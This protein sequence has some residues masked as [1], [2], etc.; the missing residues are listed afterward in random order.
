MT[1]LLGEV[2][3]RVERGRAGEQARLAREQEQRLL[4]AHAAA[5]GVDPA[6]VDP[7]ER[8]RPPDDLRH[9]R[10][11]VDLL[12]RAPRVAREPVRV[13]DRE[14]AARGQGAPDLRVAAAVEPAAV[15]RDDQRDPRVPLRAV[16]RGEH[17]VGGA[18][19]AVR[20]EVVDLPRADER[21]R[22]RRRRR[23]AAA[24]QQRRG[25]CG[26][27]QAPPDASP[28]H[29]RP[30]LRRTGGGHP[31][32]RDRG[33]R[34]GRA[35]CVAPPGSRSRSRTLPRPR[36]QVGRHVQRRGAGVDRERDR[37]EARRHA[38][39]RDP[40]P[41]A[42]PGARRRVGELEPVAAL[43]DER[44]PQRLQERRVRGAVRRQVHRPRALPVER[45]HGR[46]LAGDER[47]R[48]HRGAE[49]PVEAE[50]EL[51]GLVEVG[52]EARDVDPVDLVGAGG[53]RRRVP[54]VERVAAGADE[55]EQARAVQ[56]Q[57]AVGA[58]RL[59]AVRRRRARTRRRTARPG[60]SS[61]RRATRSRGGR[62]P[63]RRAAA[64][65]RR[66]SRRGARRSERRTAARRAGPSRAASF[67]ARAASAR[68][69]VC[70]HAV[71]DPAQALPHDRLRVQP[72]DLV[73]D[74]GRVALADEQAAGLLL[75]LAA[76]GRSRAAPASPAAAPTGRG[77]GGSRRPSRAA[78][79]PSSRPDTGSA[80]AAATSAGS[81]A[82]PP[83][84]PARPGPARRRSPPG[85]R[86]P[87]TGCRRCS[88]RSGSVPGRAARSARA[89]RAPPAPRSPHPR[90][91]AS[92]S[93]RRAGRGPR[94]R[95]RRR[96]RPACRAAPSARRASAPRPPA[97]RRPPAPRT[98]ASRC[99]RS[100][101]SRTNE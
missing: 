5:E 57:V 89:G 41:G 15:R 99:G 68:R 4:A 78:S 14:A 80:A 31:T 58:A 26:Q 97:R 23:R 34:R 79:R 76:R 27:D 29:D 47:V 70:A 96:S 33:G 1:V 13:D 43:V 44:Q 100:T 66:G 2:G 42:E 21:L 36:G 51:V 81:R 11:V 7:D 63:V 59:A 90:R 53:R 39:N 69:P 65:G 50:H 71:G 94:R 9:L 12:R 46:A 24:E 19:L 98:C 55:P 6:A 87:R 25:D 54:A 73:G 67:R 8:Q 40:P 86:T 16:P 60:S 88:A 56:E 92:A 95:R 72:V 17:D 52:E 32:R 35:S 93:R 30:E 49:H 74:V 45:G 20:G 77:R 3:D 22:L 83:D 84:G 62:A 38:G 75:P 82:R 10:E 48:R 28:S 37:P 101:L 61:C 91:A 18:A 64:P 85:T